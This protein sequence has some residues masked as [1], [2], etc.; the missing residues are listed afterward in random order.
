[1]Q[2]TK[3][4]SLSLNKEQLRLL[5]PRQLGQARGG[6]QDNGNGSTYNMCDRTNC[7]CDK[8]K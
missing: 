6:F 8:T 7:D 3:K 4:K 2:K 1:M 5:N